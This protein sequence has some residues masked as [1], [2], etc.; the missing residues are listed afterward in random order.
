[1]P[2]EGERVL[3]TRCGGSGLEIEVWRGGGLTGPACKLCNRRGYIVYSQGGCI[4]A[5][6]AK[7]LWVGLALLIVVC[8]GGFLLR[9]SLQ[10]A[11]EPAG[12]RN[13]TE[14]ALASTTPGA[15]MDGFRV[16]TCIDAVRSVSTAVPCT[17]PHQGEVYALIAVDVPAGTPFPGLERL[18]AFG[19]EHCEAGFE[20]YVGQAASRSSLR[21]AAYV[22]DADD[23][24]A[25][26][27]ALS[28]AL[29]VDGRMTT[30]ST[31]SLRGSGR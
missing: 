5:M 26:E 28:C 23:W 31:G 6:L 20:P 17:A 10:A 4:T 16:G 13:R 18:W 27:R 7:L 2:Q 30:R 1:M 25:G 14:L 9:K 29:F 3:C 19:R 15:S 21:W 22:P 11:H 24:A 12:V 8:V